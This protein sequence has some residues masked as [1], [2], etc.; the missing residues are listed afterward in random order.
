VGLTATP[1]RRDGHHPITETQLGPVR[2]TVDAES[3]AGRALALG[4]WPADLQRPG[5]LTRPEIG[6]EMVQEVF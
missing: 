4:A 2:Y 6:I 3:G 1:Q 5:R